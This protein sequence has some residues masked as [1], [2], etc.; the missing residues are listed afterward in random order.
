M[1]G[2]LLLGVF[3]EQ[4]TYNPTPEMI[5]LAVITTIIG[6]F[7]TQ[8]ITHYYKIPNIKFKPYIRRRDLI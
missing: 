5:K 1:F 3:L 8:I 4:V 6:A 7:V 2:G